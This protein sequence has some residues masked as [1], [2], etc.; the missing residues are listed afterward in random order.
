M[1]IENVI[2]EAGKNLKTLLINYTE[3]DW[4]N[5][6]FREVE[7]YSFREK[8][9]EKYFFGFD[10]KKMWTRQFILSNIKD[11]KITENNFSP[12]WEVEF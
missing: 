8:N 9:W 11:I 2:I 7:P 12:R 10:L 1:N 3:K 4:S 6:W 5:E